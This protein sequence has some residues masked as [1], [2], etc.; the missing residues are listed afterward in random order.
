MTGGRCRADRTHLSIRYGVCGN[1]RMK[2][3][4]GFGEEL[5]ADVTYRDK[6]A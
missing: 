6:K 4:P 1:V 3:T 2:N 5:D